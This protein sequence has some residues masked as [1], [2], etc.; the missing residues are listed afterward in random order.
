MTLMLFTS[1]NTLPL[2][3]AAFSLGRPDG[4]MIY[5]ETPWRE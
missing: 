5:Q 4:K 1:C 3:G 2:E